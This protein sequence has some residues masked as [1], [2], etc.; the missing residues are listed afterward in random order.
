[1][2]S[3]VSAICCLLLSSARCLLSDARYLLSFFLC[4]LSGVCFLLS[5]VC[6][7]LSD[8]GGLMVAYVIRPRVQPPYVHIIVIVSSHCRYAVVTLLSHCCYS[9]VTLFLPCCTLLFHFCPLF[10]APMC[11]PSTLT[12]FFCSGENAY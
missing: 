11:I 6:C 1:M 8:D 5:T 4:S 10:Q 9:V 12:A 7:L 3:H 2:L